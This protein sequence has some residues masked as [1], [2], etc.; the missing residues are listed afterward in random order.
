MDTA[1]VTAVAPAAPVV[2][3]RHFL[4]RLAFETDP[5][6]VATQ[7]RVAPGSIVLVDTRSAAAYAERHIAGAVSLPHATIDAAALATLPPDALVVTYCWSAA[8]NAAVK[9]AA[10]IAGLGR[11][12]KEM[13]GGIAAWEA[14]GLP[15]E[16]TARLATAS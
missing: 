16:G 9:G 3:E 1:P 8:C 12:V 11:P 13:L 7:L 4:G 15:T 5:S 2:A 10:R 14:E 6:D